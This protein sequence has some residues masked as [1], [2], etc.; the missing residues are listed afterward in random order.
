MKPKIIGI[1]IVVAIMLVGLFLIGFNSKKVE[2]EKDS[3]IVGIFNC[4][5]NNINVSFTD[6]D[7]DI[8]YEIFNGKKLYKDGLSCGFIEDV[9]IIINDNKKFYFAL[10]GDPYVYFENEDRFFTL[11]DDENTKLKEVLSKYGFYFPCI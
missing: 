1:V 6:E 4:R 11:S 8:I 2:I 9:S 5:D 10:D 7:I 3:K